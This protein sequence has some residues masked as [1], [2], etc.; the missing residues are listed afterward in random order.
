M[1]WESKDLPN[2]F[3]S[4]KSHAEF[5]FGGPL[6]MNTEEVK[7]NY[8]MIWAGEKGRQ[9]FST[10][11]LQDDDKKMLESYYTGFKSYSKP[12]SNQI[13]ARY[14]LWCREQEDSEKFEHFVTSLKLL[15]NDCGYDAAIHDKMIRDS[16]VFG[17]KS[18]KIREKLINEGS[19]L[20]LQKCLDIA[21]TYELSQEQLE[22]IDNQASI[23]YVKSRAAT[24][25]DTTHT[26]NATWTS[27]HKDVYEL[28]EKSF[29]KRHL[30]GKRTAV[31]LLFKI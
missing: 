12:R 17:V 13:Y 27:S 15:L 31:Q 9:I 18:S 23:N 7:C 16:I 21:R 4:F 10:W 28:W 2:A 6:Q 19:D 29:Q 8:L 24:N 30:P 1:D 26:A 5:M 14:K 3:K 11:N 20:T 22:V 25:D